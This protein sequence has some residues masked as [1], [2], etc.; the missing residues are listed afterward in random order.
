MMEDSV[1]R[2][3]GGL[4]GARMDDIAA[5]EIRKRLQ[6]AWT[7]RATGRRPSRFG[8]RGF[9]RALAVAALVV[10]LNQL[11]NSDNLDIGT[12]IKLT[13]GTPP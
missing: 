11:A 9:A 4:K 2:A 7:E 3:L 1:A 10:D 8:V 13:R 6:L 12:N 5:E